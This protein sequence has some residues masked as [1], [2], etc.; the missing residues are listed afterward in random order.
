MLEITNYIR[1]HVR[2]RQHPGRLDMEFG[3]RHLNLLGAVLLLTA[4]V[5]IFVYG[6]R[7]ITPVVC[8]SRAWPYWLSSSSS[9][10]NSRRRPCPMS[11]R[12]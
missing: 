8:S 5:L 10:T 9:G 2:N 4:L 7:S 12:E 3:Y 1:D 6:D 11:E